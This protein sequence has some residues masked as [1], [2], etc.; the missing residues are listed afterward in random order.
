VGAD[1]DLPFT[2]GLWREVNLRPPEIF[3]TKKN[4]RDLLL[5]D[6]LAPIQ[7]GLELAQAL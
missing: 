6:I 1:A 2:P 4:E 3:V 5:R 7:P